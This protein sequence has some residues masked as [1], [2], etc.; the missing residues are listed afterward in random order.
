MR[1]IDRVIEFIR[2]D[3][4]IPPVHKQVLIDRIEQPPTRQELDAA[5]RIVYPH[6]F[7]SNPIETAA[8]IIGAIPVKERG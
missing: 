8:E 6:V 3:S 2:R 4:R 7:E 1:D 5:A